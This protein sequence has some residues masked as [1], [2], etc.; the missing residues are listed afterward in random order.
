MATIK[1]TVRVRELISKDGKR[2]IAK[3]MWSDNPKS[4]EAGRAWYLV[5]DGNV[6]FPTK[7]EGIP[8][9]YSDAAAMEARKW[10]RTYLLHPD[11]GYKFA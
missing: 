3:L 1:K 11:R 2:I 5:V 10:A 9:E 4:A 6:V 8:S 7:T